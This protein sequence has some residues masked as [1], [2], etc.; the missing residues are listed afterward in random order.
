MS[1][2]TELDTS[3]P[4]SLT[5][6]P[7]ELLFHILSHLDIPDLLLLSR[8]SHRFRTLCQDPTLHTLRLRRTSALLNRYIQGGIGG[9]PELKQLLD[10]R[11]YVTR[12]TLVARALSRQ[13]VRIMLGRK[14]DPGRRVRRE[15]LVGRGV[16]LPGAFAG[17][18]GDKRRM[19]ER[20]LVR[21]LLGRKLERRPSREVLVG[22]GVL[23]RECVVEGLAPGLVGMKRKV[24]RERVKDGL[25]GWVEEWR[26][27][28]W[29]RWQR[30]EEEEVHPDVRRLVRM[31]ARWD[32]RNAEVRWGRDARRE[33][34]EAPPRAKVLGL[35]RFW[36]KIG[37]EGA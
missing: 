25:R 10:R 26:R 4:S 6:L 8:T 22:W 11:I 15:E 13:M 7:D 16:L 30:E 19:V 33:K 36:E 9:R 34:N 18:M 24:E 2:F 27:R 31:F 14:L 32:E 5:S 28:G 3:L 12:T 21:M 1:T 37:R 20:Q 23:P 35:R 29:E 17:D